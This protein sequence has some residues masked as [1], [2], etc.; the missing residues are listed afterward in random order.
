MF[1]FFPTFE[2]N[3]FNLHYLCGDTLIKCSSHASSSPL[4]CIRW[5]IAEL[6]KSQNDI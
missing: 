1:Y 6:K 2:E 3:D 5:Q 4:K